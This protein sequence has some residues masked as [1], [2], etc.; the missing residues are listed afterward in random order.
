MSKIEAYRCDYCREIVEVN[1]CVGVSPQPDL[2]DKLHGYPV[3]YKCEKA[4]IHLC[5]KCYN[6]YA[7]SIAE[8][9]T[10]R[11]KDEEGYKRKLEE[12]SY[13]LRFQAVSNYAKTQ[14]AKKTR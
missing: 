7:V 10:N 13:S 6:L 4:D 1:D 14:Q 11:R 2:F 9:E 3:I 8:R 5:G 12:L